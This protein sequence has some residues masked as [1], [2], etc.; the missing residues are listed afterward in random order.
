MFRKGS[1]Q[2]FLLVIAT[3]VLAI[4]AIVGVMTFSY[5]LANERGQI[6]IVVNDGMVNRSTYIVKR[7]EKEEEDALELRQFFMPAW[8]ERDALLQADSYIDFSVNNYDYTVEISNIEVMP[9]STRATVKVRELM[10]HI[11]ATPM[12]TQSGSEGKQVPE[13]DANIYQVHL[14]KAED[15]R[16]GR[17]RWY[18]NDMVILDEGTDAQ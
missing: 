8:L 10:S 18:I 17:E 9:W 14:V 11:E 4:A 16:T 2:R 6:Y 13:W 7:A 3:W 1:W 5:A 12:E 15:A